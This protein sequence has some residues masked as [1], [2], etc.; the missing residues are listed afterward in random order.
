MAVGRRPSGVGVISWAMSAKSKLIEAIQKAK[1]SPVHESC[2]YA[3][4]P[5]VDW[6]E[7]LGPHH[8]T[9][10]LHLRQAAERLIH[11]LHHGGHRKDLREVALFSVSLATDGSPAAGEAGRR[12]YQVLVFEPSL[13]HSV[14]KDWGSDEPMSE[15]EV[16]ERLR[17]GVESGEYVGWR[18]VTVHQ[19]VLGRDETALARLNNS[20]GGADA[21][22]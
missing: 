18:V 13:T 19:D 16:V 3:F 2:I 4:G 10:G 21:S 5:F 15:Q 22:G 6:I 14:W 7:S 11:A 1:P 8:N 17:A 20:K 12:G 9:V